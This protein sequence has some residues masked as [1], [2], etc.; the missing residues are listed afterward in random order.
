FDVTF[1][2]ADALKPP[3]QGQKEIRG[4]KISFKTHKSLTKKEAWDLF[5]T[6]LDTAGFSVIPHTDPNI[7]RIVSAGPTAQKSPLPTFIGVDYT[8]LPDTD[9]LIRY[10]YFIENSTVDTIEGVLSRIISNPS[11]LIM[12]KEHK[13]FI[14]TDK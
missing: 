4:N 2:T 3:V 1:I 8:T 10:L 14:L 9:D 13:G 6:F 11:V 7:Y 5:V 12:L